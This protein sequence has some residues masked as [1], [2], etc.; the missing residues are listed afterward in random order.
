MKKHSYWLYGIVV[1]LGIAAGLA[2]KYYTRTFR[3][4]ASVGEGRGH[5]SK[6]IQQSMTTSVKSA[7][8]KMD[9]NGLPLREQFEAA[10]HPQNVLKLCKILR[11]WALTDPT[12]ALAAWEGSAIPWVLGSE[13]PREAALAALLE[14]WAEHDATGAA[15]W[16]N[17]RP[18]VQCPLTKSF[19]DAVGK[20]DPQL[21]MDLAYKN[22]SGVTGM[23]A[24]AQSISIAYGSNPALAAGNV[25]E[26]L[27][28]TKDDW[29]AFVIMGTLL[30]SHGPD[31]AASLAA[32]LLK[33]LP[34]G[35]QMTNSIAGF[36]AGS[37]S[38]AGLERVL[39]STDAASGEHLLDQI[40][41]SRGAAHV[42]A[43]P[44]GGALNTWRYVLRTN[45]ESGFEYVAK[46]GEG[47]MKVFLESRIPQALAA[48]PEKALLSFAKISGAAVPE[49]ARY[50][51]LE[52]Q[53]RQGVAQA[54]KLAERITDPVAKDAYLTAL[55]AKKQARRE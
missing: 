10:L 30:Q 14:G 41:E 22:C 28:H 20:V 54:R 16:L 19:I 24:V 33:D 34:A 45:P 49:A 50:L 51:A 2:A 35:T 26:M 47:E 37:N 55:N 8:P 29:L 17:Q 1:V 18:D 32:A 46:M 12:A 21:A 9:G 15:L 13:S 43:Y 4:D 7:D 42:G 36:S 52:M 27:K 25:T 39:K 3:A 48:D 5:L 40:R 23:N 31:A 11:Q 44:L 6:P 53:N 38:I